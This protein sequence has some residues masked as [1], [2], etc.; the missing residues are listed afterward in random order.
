MPGSV[1][2]C[3]TGKL[4]WLRHAHARAIHEIL[5]SD[6]E[7]ASCP[8]ARGNHPAPVGLFDRL[9]HRLGVGSVFLCS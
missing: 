2:L 7:R 9:E 8:A 1:A 5:G 3:P 6:I 4:D